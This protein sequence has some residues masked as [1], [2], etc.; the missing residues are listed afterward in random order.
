[1]A[2]TP[3]RFV[4]RYRGKNGMEYQLICPNCKKDNLWYNSTRGSGQCFTCPGNSRSGNLSF[5]SRQLKL[6]FEGLDSCDLDEALHA[7]IKPRVQ[8]EVIHYPWQEHFSAKW[9]LE[10]VRRCEPE[11]LA[12]A[13]VWYDQGKDKVCIPI[14]RILPGP[15]P[16]TAPYMCRV[17]DPE[18]SGWMVQPREANKENYWFDPVGI[19]N[20]DYVVLVEGVFDVMTPKLSGQ[21]IALLGTKLYE[22]AV[23]WLCDRCPKV[24]IWMDPDG[25]GVKAAADI[26]TI[27]SGLMPLARVVYEKEPGDC[28]PH[29]ARSIIQGALAYVSGPMVG[30]E[31]YPRLEAA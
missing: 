3:R 5:T 8:Q 15:V 23:H 22:D 19:V 24:I 6:H 29:E 10:K 4:S 31:Y 16:E 2:W 14:Q 20:P 21:A 17:A 12:Q 1:M 27:L 9:Y 7:I 26:T 28:T 25:P 18:V 30:E 13:G 11:V